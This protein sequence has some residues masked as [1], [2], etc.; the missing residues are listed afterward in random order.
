MY[1]DGC[2]GAGSQSCWNSLSMINASDHMFQYS[3]VPLRLEQESK[4][5]WK[6]PTPNAA[7]CTRPVYL[8]RL[9]EDDPAVL[10]LVI[11]T[12]DKAREELATLI[13]ITDKDGVIYKV[14]HEI[15]DTM[16]DL[17]F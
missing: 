12:T 2:D 1:K 13:N 6:N 14:Q 16:K 10:N 5:L 11:P 15:H 4:V 9:H 17:K 7:N 3:V 8:L